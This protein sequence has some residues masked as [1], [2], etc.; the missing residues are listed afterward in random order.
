MQAGLVAY[1]IYIISTSGRECTDHG[2]CSVTI[3]LRASPPLCFYASLASALTDSLYLTG[4]ICTL[5]NTCY[6]H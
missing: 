6:K 1:Q 4:L 2:H 5:T 3:D